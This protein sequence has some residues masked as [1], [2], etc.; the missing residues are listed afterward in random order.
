MRIAVLLLFAVLYTDVNATLARTDK[1]PSLLWTF[2]SEYSV[3]KSRTRRHINIDSIKS[4]QFD[5]SAEA[6]S[7]TVPADQ[8]TWVGR[9]RYTLDG[10]QP[11]SSTVIKTVPTIIVFGFYAS[12]IGAMHVYQSQ[13]IW[14]DVTSFRFIEDSN[15]ELYTDKFGHFLAASFMCAAPE[16]CL[17]ASGF[18]PDA[19]ANIGAAMGFGY[20]LYVEILDGYGVDW[21]FSMS[22]FIANTAGTIWFLG[23]HHIP[24]LQN[25]QPKWGMYPNN[26]IGNKHR[27]RATSFIDEYGAS[28]WFMSMNIHNLLP[29]S[30]QKSYPRWLMVSIGYAARNVDDPT[31]RNLISIGLDYDI[32]SILPEGGSLWNW[33]R[34]TIRFIKFPAPA[35]VFSN[36]D[37]PRFRLL[38]PLQIELGGLSF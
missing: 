20:Q 36:H 6:L 30:W 11:N 12:F 24:V 34:Q 10:S 2:G 35:I 22:D 28:T 15:Q 23:Q 37:K 32:Q 9:P 7:A 33:V 21:G 3:L 16:E 17:L 4:K 29:E 31:L 5:S 26:W 1:H 8:F 27:P 19:S 25:F 18:S 14:K 13:T 38:F